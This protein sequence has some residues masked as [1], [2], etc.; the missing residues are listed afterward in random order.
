MLTLKVNPYVWTNSS[1]DIKSSVLSV[2]LKTQD[3]SRLNISDLRDPI[4]LLVPEKEHE[5]PI[6][7]DTQGHL[8]LKPYNGSGAIRYHK[9]TFENELEAA[10]VEIRPENN[11]IFDVFVSA[12][13]KPTPKSYTFR[14]KIPD[15]SL[16]GD[17]KPGTG[18]SNCTS[19]PYM[20]SLSSNVT[21]DIGVH[22]IGISLAIETKETN[23]PNKQRRI[24]RS[25]KESHGRQ[26][27]SCIGV[28]DPPTTPPPTPE[29]I[30]PKYD[31]RTDVNYTMTVTMR[32]CMY[33][34]EVKQA[35]TSEGCKVFH[36]LFSL[37]LN[38]T[39]GA[40]VLYGFPGTKA[41]G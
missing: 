41:I 1:K 31:A 35:W 30:V 21:G 27:R 25:C 36:S 16:C 19:N 39:T 28:K 37:S 9:I 15:I 10:L 33:W 3:G 22:Y 38:P 20:S 8:F 5:V 4:E 26:K 7:N 6:K 12:G 32:S 24:E 11:T 2:D 23:T 13:V 29:V 34:S 17:F 40:S 18:C 14:K